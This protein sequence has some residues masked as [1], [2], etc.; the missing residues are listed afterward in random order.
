MVS[1]GRT[2][3]RMQHRRTHFPEW[4]HFRKQ[5]HFPEKVRFPEQNAVSDA[6]G[7][8]AQARIPLPG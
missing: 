8:K 1:I 3:G 6:P 7:A 2:G 5:A 4:A